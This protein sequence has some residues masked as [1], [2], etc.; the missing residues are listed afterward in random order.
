MTCGRLLLILKFLHFRNNEDPTC[1]KID[2]NRDRLHKI[3][4]LIDLMRA[5]LK[6]LSA[7]KKLDCGQ[8]V[9]LIQGSI[10]FQ[11]IY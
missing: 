2:E 1:D 3:Q 4:P 11:V 9:G 7:W 8:I 5:L 10:A 6:S